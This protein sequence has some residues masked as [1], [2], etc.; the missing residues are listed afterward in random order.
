[1]TRTITFIASLA[2][3]FTARG[4]YVIKEEL[5]NS[6]QVQQIT[7][8]IK[9]AKVREDIG[10]QNS[11]IIDSNTGET[12][13][14]LHSQKAF[15]KINPEQLKAQAEA[16]KDLLGAKT[17]N[18]ANIELKPTG[19][20]ET[21]NGFATEEYTTNF[22][23]VQ[24]SIFIAKGFPNYQKLVEALYRVQSGPAM[25]IL[26]SMSIPPDKYPGLPI[27]TTESIMGQKIV[28]ILDSAQ[29]TDLPDTDFIIPPDYKEL[30]PR[31][32]GK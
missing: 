31:E 16:L 29:E 6:G 15:L 2:L 24:L 32:T 20:Q 14:L 8:K 22:N 13:L 11:A 4:D 19:K 12:T 21:I 18:P 1:M 27:R 7:L 30:N 23:G 5:E 25:D 26:R 9:D 17:E 3:V 28:V 10:G